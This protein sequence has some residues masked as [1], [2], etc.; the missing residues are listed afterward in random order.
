[1]PSGTPLLRP[2]FGVRIEH[3]KIKRQSVLSFV[4]SRS[5]VRITPFHPVSD[6]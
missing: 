4:A 1:M 5:T 6:L 2:A 3:Q